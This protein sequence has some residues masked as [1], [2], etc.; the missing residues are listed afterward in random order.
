LERGV[1]HP[2]R[3][4]GGRTAA[5]ENRFV[6]R[7][8]RPQVHEARRRNL[9]NEAVDAMPEIVGMRQTGRDVGNAQRPAFESLSRERFGEAAVQDETD[10]RVL[11]RMFRDE[12]AGRMLDFLERESFHFAALQSSAVKFQV[13]SHGAGINHAQRPGG[14]TSRKVAGRV[15]RAGVVAYRGRAR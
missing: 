3:E 14:V 4:P 8:Q 12:N 1:V 9:E 13:G 10:V 15:A 6:E 11:M 5:N 7:E 2:Q